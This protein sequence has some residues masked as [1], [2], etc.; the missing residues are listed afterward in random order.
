MLLLFYDSNYRFFSA[1][2]LNSWHTEK[3]LQFFGSLVVQNRKTLFLLI[4]MKINLLLFLKLDLG[5]VC[6]N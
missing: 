2:L 5:L 6:V 4:K 1:K 3:L